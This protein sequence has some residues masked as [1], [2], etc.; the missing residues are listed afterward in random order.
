MAAPGRYDRAAAA[1]ILARVAGPFDDVPARAHFPP[2]FHVE[3]ELTPLTPAPGSHLTS[4]QLKYLTTRLQPCEPQQVTSATHRLL[5]HDSDGTANV[6][7]CGPDGPLVAL[8]ARETVLVL[9]RA[10]AADEEVH[11]RAAAL[12]PDDRAVMAATTTDQDP[13][14]IL[15]VG[16][17]TTARALVQHSWLDIRR[18]P[19]ELARELRNS[20]LFAVVANTWFW[21]LQSETY[22]RGMIPVAL[23]DRPDGGLTYSAATRITLRALKDATIAR[24]DHDP[25][26]ARQYGPLTY[27]EVP[28]CLANMPTTTTGERSTLLAPVVALFVETY[29]RL[30]DVVHVSG[31]PDLRRNPECPRCSK[32]PT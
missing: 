15:N 30:L 8:A 27:G 13:V 25:G 31:N 16:F 20:G 7:H 28:R 12:S 17:E 26:V 32:S 23:E 6:S 11:R 3:P 10:L 1:G 4:A 19:A 29:V 2:A 22:R 5:W 24:P 14:E 18:T 9:R 21:G